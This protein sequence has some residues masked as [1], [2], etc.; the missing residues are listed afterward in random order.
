MY[1]VQCLFSGFHCWREEGKR[2]S[3]DKETHQL[4]EISPE[5]FWGGTKIAF[6]WLV[7][8]ISITDASVPLLCSGIT[9][10]KNSGFENI[11]LKKP[12]SYLSVVKISAVQFW[13][14]AV[15]L[16]L[17]VTAEWIAYF[18][19]YFCKFTFARSELWIID[20]SVLDF[21]LNL[22]LNS[23]LTTQKLIRGLWVKYTSLLKN[24]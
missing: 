15:R 12:Q 2:Y 10:Y 17:I 5:L 4:K 24:S 19:Y 20:D 21:F 1:L 22:F 14:L 9:L 6:A 16:W 18:M 8:S 23:H 3:T 11:S 13:Y 7:Q